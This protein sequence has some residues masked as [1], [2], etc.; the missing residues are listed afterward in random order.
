MP[1]SPDTLLRRVKTTLLRHLLR[2]TEMPS[3]LVFTRT[4]QSAR[5]GGL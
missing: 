1:T 4:K 2:H 3:V 5:H